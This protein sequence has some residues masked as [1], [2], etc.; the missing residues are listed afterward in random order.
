MVDLT[1]TAERYEARGLLP[2]AYTHRPNTVRPSSTTARKPNATTRN[3][4]GVVPP[5]DPV[6][7]LRSTGEA[8]PAGVPPAGDIVPETPELPAVTPIRHMTVAGLTS[9][10]IAP[11]EPMP[12]SKVAVPGVEDQVVVLPKVTAIPHMALSGS[13]VPE[14]VP[15]EPERL[16]RRMVPAVD[17]QE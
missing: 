1:P 4:T 6:I 12:V 14:V 13:K 17:A 16:L 15:A 5:S 7:N 10:E 8:K 3:T 11:P 2:S 9:Y